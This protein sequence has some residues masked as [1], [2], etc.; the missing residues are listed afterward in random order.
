MPSKLKP[1]KKPYSGASFSMPDAQA[2]RAELEAKGDSNEANIQKMLSAAAERLKD[3][4]KALAVKV[5]TR[6][7][8]KWSFTLGS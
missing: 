2:A 6:R 7:G 8:V 3:K 5:G 4:T 1:A